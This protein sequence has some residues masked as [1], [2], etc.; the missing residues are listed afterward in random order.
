VQT[1]RGSITTAAM[2]E[3]RERVVNYN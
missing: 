3:K 2:L 1:K